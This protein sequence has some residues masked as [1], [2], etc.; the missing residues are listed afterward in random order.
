MDSRKGQAV[1]LVTHQ[2]LTVIFAV[3]YSFFSTSIFLIMKAREYCCCAIPVVNAGIYAAL[4][5]QL[6]LG[7]LV[8]TLSIATPSSQSSLTNFRLHSKLNYILFLSCWCRNPIIC[9]LDLGNHCVRR[10]WSSNPRFYWRFTG[11][12]VSAKQ[13]TDHL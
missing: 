1:S 11:M 2:P 6:S 13:A 9:T 12:A 5:E 10:C 4:I 7:V 3:I 8:G